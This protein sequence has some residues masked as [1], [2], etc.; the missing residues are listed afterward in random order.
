[1]ADVRL[2]IAN[3]EYIVTCADGE[4]ARLMDLGN[5]VNEMAIEA[6]GSAGSLN[7]SR[8]LLYSA[9]LLADKMHE[10]RNSAA[11]AQT[12]A[13]NSDADHA[14]AME[15]LADRIEKLVEQLEL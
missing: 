7:E 12:I 9:L 15:K 5:I 3:R 10:A 1:M 13:S 6:G 4:E 11:P 2:M 14:M 8:T